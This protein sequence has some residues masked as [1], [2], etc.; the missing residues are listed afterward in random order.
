MTSLGTTLV[1]IA[2]DV[3][4][5]YQEATGGVIDPDVGLLKITSAQ[6]LNLKSL[7]IHVYGVCDLS[8]FVGHWQCGVTF[9]SSSFFT[10]FHLN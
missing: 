2:T 3:F 5:R 7:F 1:Q 10:R 9:L 8:C 6:Y 4:E